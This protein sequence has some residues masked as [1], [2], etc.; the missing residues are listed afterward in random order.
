MAQ[1]TGKD[2][3][4]RPENVHQLKYRSSTTPQ[5]N[6]KPITSNQLS[7]IN[8]GR[9]PEWIGGVGEQR[10]TGGLFLH[11]DITNALIHIVKQAV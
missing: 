1:Q 4:R 2:S 5:G 3:G 9:G 6:S 10:Q 7:H 11:G 8:L